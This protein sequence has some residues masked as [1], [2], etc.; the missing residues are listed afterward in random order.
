MKNSLS[1]S[2]LLCVRGHI[3]LLKNLVLSRV[4][5]IV[6]QYNEKQKELAV[7]GFGIK[8]LSKMVF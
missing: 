1:S 4:D 5:N 3:H 6:I 8:N 2:S 7:G